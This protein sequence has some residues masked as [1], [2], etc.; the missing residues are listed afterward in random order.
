MAEQRRPLAAIVGQRPA[1]ERVVVTGMGV[2][3]S[4]GP[5]VDT[6]WQGILAGRSG[7]S[8]IT[9]IDVS[10]FPTT[11]SGWIPGFETP[12]FV[13]RK[14]ARHIARFAQMGLHAAHAA[15]EDAGLGD[16]LESDRAGVLVGSAVG[17]LD[18][19]ERA[20]RIMLEKGAMRISP[21]YIVM[22]P[23]N[24]AAFHIAHRFRLLGYN[25]SV[26]TACAAGTQAIGE[27]AE[28]IRRGDADI[29]LAGGAEAGLSQ[30]A[31]AAFCVGNAFSTRNDPPEASSRPFDK[32][33]DGFVGGEG[34]GMVVLE[35]LDLA[36]A[37]GARIR[38]EVLGY[39][40][41]N[42]AYHLIAPDPEG[43]GAARAMRA[44]LRRAGVSPT[45]VEY[46]NAHATGTPLGDVSETKA[47]KAV[48]GQRAYAIP[49]SAT[50]SMIGHLFGAAG[51]VE[52]I[53]TLLALRDG[54]LPPTI[55]L[56]EPDP[57]CDLDYVPHTARR[58]PIDVAMSN[59]FGLGGQDAA[60]IL[61]RWAEG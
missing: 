11:V 6:F 36:L 57:E 15:L 9:G 34:S 10:E 18:E 37:R 52:G 23:A 44:A 45:E 60:I 13:P 12:P 58:A 33:R 49:V 7:I 27:A 59:S 1:S 19:T 22:A 17:G 29:M 4:L 21:F 30:L 53:A 20:V 47:I 25:N 46:I 14:E 55:N 16:A 48:F 56:D 31:L 61:A 54:M 40:A 43:A 8:R 5:T 3:T 39:G 2:I 50:K 51:A 28:V 41:S 35:R 26:V 32:D 24:L 42:D 38:G